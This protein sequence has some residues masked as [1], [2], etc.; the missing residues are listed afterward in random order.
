MRIPLDPPKFTDLVQTLVR[1]ALTP[2]IVFLPSRR[3]CDDAVESFRSIRS[4]GLS[5]DQIDQIE[6]IIDSFG[7]EAP[8]LRKHRH[9]S[10]VF[11]KGVAAHHA[12]HL[13]AWKHLVEKLMSS[14]L[15]RAVFSTSTLAAG[16]DMPARSVVITASSLRGDEGHRDIKAFELAQMTGR[17]GRRGRDKVGFAVFIP[18]PFQDIRL[19]QERLFQPPEPIESSFNANYT[20]VLNLLQQLS[21]E[22]ARALVERSFLQFQRIEQAQRLR[23]RLERIQKLVNDDAAQCPAGNRVKTI[24]RY[25]ELEHTLNRSRKQVKSLR[26]MVDREQVAAGM[27][28]EWTKSLM[29]GLEKEETTLRTLLAKRDDLPCGTCSQLKRCPQRAGEIAHNYEELTRLEDRMDSFE[30]GLWSGFE[31]CVKI[32]QH[33]DYIDDNWRPTEQGNWASFL[34][35]DNTLFIAELLRDG[36]FDTPDART[37]AALCGGLAAEDRDFTTSYHQPE[38]FLATLR[39]AV[40]IAKA[41]EAIQ[42]QHSFYCPMW[43]DKEAAKLVWLWGDVTRPWEELLKLTEASEGDIVR[44]ILRTA[45]LLGQLTG[46]VD[47]H[48][49]I[50]ARAREATRLIRRPPIEE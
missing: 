12:G 16:I 45:D 48:P 27:D 10:L 19:I 49:H 40:G 4:V 25:Q 46:L 33:F 2:A 32:L 7:D 34:R 11:R 22:S 26:R 28:P 47:S 37:M 9:Y 43:I 21:P 50:A 15:L 8:F 17:A 41:I 24:M 29:E 39:K 3:A 35:V 13:P 5:S 14:G 44:L 6:A 36:F 42:D 20:M 31:D 18:G 38:P 23:P 1:H 30:H